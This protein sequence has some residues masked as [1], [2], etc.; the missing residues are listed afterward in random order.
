MSRRKKSV[1]G[2]RSVD[3]TFIDYVERW[4]H[5]FAALETFKLRNELFA[6]IERERKCYEIVDGETHVSGIEL[7]TNVQL[8]Y[9]W[10]Q[11]LQRAENLNSLFV[12]LTP[13]EIASSKTKFLFSLLAQVEWK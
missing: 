5:L 1:D 12:A 7:Q 2:A 10:D 6:A 9:T 13:I 11:R 4:K 3:W 8:S